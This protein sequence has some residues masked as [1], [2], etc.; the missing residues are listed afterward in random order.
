M[1]SCRD[2]L[3]AHDPQEGPI[4]RQCKDI[5]L[6]DLRPVYKAIR[7]VHAERGNFGLA[8]IPRMMAAIH[9]DSLA[10]SRPDSFTGSRDV[11]PPYRHLSAIAMKPN[12]HICN[13]VGHF[14]VYTRSASSTSSKMMDNSHG[15]AKNTRTTSADSTN[16]TVD[17]DKVLCRTHT[18]KQPLIAM[19]DF[20]ARRTEWA[21]G[22]THGVATPGLR[23]SGE[24]AAPT[25]VL[26]EEN[27]QRERP[28]IS[29]TAMEVHPT[30]ATAAEQSHKA[31]T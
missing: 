22:N 1:D 13:R 9:G 4:C 30:T 26:L 25:T 17:A 15:I 14:K 24:P 21:D 2:C 10:C 3:N 12:Y 6:Q 11:V 27:D 29:F 16:E 5:L 18:I 20:C 31:A 23:V 8:N 19:L 7:Q 28:D